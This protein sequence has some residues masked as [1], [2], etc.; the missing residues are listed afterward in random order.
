M[1]ANPMPA[2]IKIESDTELVTLAD[3]DAA[4]G[5][6]PIPPDEQNGVI[7]SSDEEFSAHLEAQP[8]DSSGE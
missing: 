6:A 7:Y 5:A 1:A 2:A 8:F 3:V 4:V